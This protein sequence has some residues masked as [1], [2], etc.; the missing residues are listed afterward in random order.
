M[1]GSLNK[2]QLIGHLGADP[3]IRRGQSGAVVAQLRIA[4]SESWRDKN[5]GERKERTEW[6]RVVIFG[7]SDGSSGLP[8]IAEKYTK[9]GSK[10]YIEG[11]LATRKWTDQQGQDRWSTE[12]ILR[13]FNGTLTLLDR[14]ERAP[15]PEENSYG[16]AKSGGDV[17]RSGGT[18]A[19]SGRSLNEDMGD[20]I[21]F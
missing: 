9:K 3:E 11:Q 19:A 14:A 16:T 15:A 1:S 20:E 5:T 4:T 10:V 2:V 7:P 21:P 18:A 13:P 12:I 6:H 17:G 8:E